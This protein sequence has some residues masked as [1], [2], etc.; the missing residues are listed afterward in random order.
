MQENHWEYNREHPHST[1]MFPS[2]TEL[3]DRPVIWIWSDNQESKV[4]SLLPTLKDWTKLSAE[5]LSQGLL[6]KNMGLIH[7]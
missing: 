3:R 1:Y 4:T 7:V 2:E 5:G 6:L